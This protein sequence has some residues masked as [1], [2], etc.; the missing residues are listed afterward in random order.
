MLISRSRRRYW[1]VTLI[2]SIERLPLRYPSLVFSSH[3]VFLSC[4]LSFFFFFPL[5]QTEQRWRLQGFADLAWKWGKALGSSTC[6]CACVLSAQLTFT[7]WGSFIC[8]MYCSLGT[9]SLVSFSRNILSTSTHTLQLW[10]LDTILTHNLPLVISSPAPP[11][12]WTEEFLGGFSRTHPDSLRCVCVCVCARSYV[13]M[14]QPMNKRN[15]REES[16]LLSPGLFSWLAAG[17][18]SL[19]SSLLLTY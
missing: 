19:I 16:Y 1:L 10:P 15:K 3:S 4:L 9:W 13:C 2:S 18:I 12:M 11:C 5:S 7:I 8:I 6:F 17:A 14:A